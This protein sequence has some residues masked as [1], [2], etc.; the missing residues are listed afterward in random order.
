MVRLSKTLINNE[1][2]DA[3]LLGLEMR[4]KQLDIQ[5]L[6]VRTRLSRGNGHQ[7]R[8]WAGKKNGHSIS[9]AGR[10]RIAAAQRRRWAEYR[11]SAAKS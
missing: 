7:G 4:K 3:A 8:S 6:E 2:L 5:I 10:R 1:L 9:A 11:K